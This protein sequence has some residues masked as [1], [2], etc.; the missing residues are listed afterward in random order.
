VLKEKASFHHNLKMPLPEKIGV[1]NPAASPIAG[2]TRLNA[3]CEWKR[4][5]LV[6][7]DDQ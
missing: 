3:E 5:A 1:L 7:V 6:V 4:K 2:A